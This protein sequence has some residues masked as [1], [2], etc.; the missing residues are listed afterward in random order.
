MKIKIGKKPPHW[1]G[2][3]S[4][5]WV[6]CLDCNSTMPVHFNDKMEGED[7]KKLE[8]LRAGGVVEMEG[9]CPMCNFRIER[10]MGPTLRMNLKDDSKKE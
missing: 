6:E 9:R 5:D 7:K 3:M 2:E 1:A 10:K 4:E 8:D